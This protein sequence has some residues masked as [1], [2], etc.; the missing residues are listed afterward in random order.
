MLCLKPLTT[1]TALFI[2]VT[3]CST[4]L[5]FVMPRFVLY[6]ISKP[7]H[8]SFY[9]L[10]VQRRSNNLDIVGLIGAVMQLSVSLYRILYFRASVFILYCMYYPVIVHILKSLGGKLVLRIYNLTTFHRILRWNCMNFILRFHVDLIDFI[11]SANGL[12]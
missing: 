6:C 7:L 10:K 12:S 3:C 11:R 4:L 1:P 5:L 9:T 8:C 2:T